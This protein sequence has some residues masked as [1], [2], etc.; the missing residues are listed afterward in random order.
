MRFAATSL[1]LITLSGL[2]LG[3]TLRAEPIP[4]RYGQGSSHGFLALKTY[5][6][7]RMAL[8]MTT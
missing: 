5:S 7:S 4:V 3:A 2:L 1:G 8:W 6:A